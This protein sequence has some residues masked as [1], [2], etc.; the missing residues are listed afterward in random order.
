[1]LP[2]LAPLRELTFLSVV[3]RFLCATL[4]GAV[5]GFE[6]GRTH[7]TAGLRTHIVVCIG[8]A[9]VMILNQYLLT[10]FQTPSDPARLGAQVISGI[11]FLGAGTIVVTGHQ[12]GRQ[13]KG[14]TTAAGLWASAC[15]GLV[16]GSGY[17]EV[18]IIMCVLLFAVIATLSRLSDRYFRDSIVVRYYIEYSIDA[19]FSTVL[20]VIRHE[21]WHLTH[22]E[23]VPSKQQ[24]VN[25]VMLDVQKV[26][27]KAE[28]V[29]LLNS[30]KNTT[31]V[32]YV[33]DS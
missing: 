8:S 24:D 11:G 33:V 31:G 17:Y 9:S 19:R 26:G 14:L 21:Q 23:M 13:I 3:V 29:D 12:R 2:V 16:V 7:H 6:R 28:C 1:M 32:M 27:A 18:A 15:M 4:C 25:C 22:I 10:Y 30:L 20:D 5:I